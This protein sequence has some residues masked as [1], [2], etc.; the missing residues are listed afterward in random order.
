MGFDSSLRVSGAS[1]KK[2]LPACHPARQVERS[3]HQPPESLLAIPIRSWVSRR[4]AQEM[5]SQSGNWT[6]HRSVV[7]LGEDIHTVAG[8][9]A[10]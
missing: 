7:R 4:Q 9:S 10:Y 8:P 1:G 2:S 5:H 6:I 3:D